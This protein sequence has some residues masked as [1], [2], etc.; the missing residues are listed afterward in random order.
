VKA[1]ERAALAAAR[2]ARSESWRMVATSV[3]DGPLEA[4]ERA[5]NAS[6]ER[7]FGWSFPY[8]PVREAGRLAIVG[9]SIISG[10]TR[11]SC[12]QSANTATVQYAAWTFRRPRRPSLPPARQPAR[13]VRVC[14]RLLKRGEESTEGALGGRP[15]RTP[16]TADPLFRLG[17]ATIRRPPVLRHCPPCERKGTE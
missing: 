12:E 1:S 11:S 8:E 14:F 13:L 15:F 9:R 7:F 16:S 4:C 3:A 6:Q 2:P 17:R 10:G 5:M